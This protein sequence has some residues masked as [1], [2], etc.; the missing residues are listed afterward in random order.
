M[1]DENVIREVNY[2]QDNNGC[3]IPIGFTKRTDGYWQFQHKGKK[4]PVHRYNYESTKGIIPKGYVLRHECDNRECV[5][6]EHLLPGTHADNVRDR[7]LRGRSATGSDN[8]RSKLTEDLVRE[9][10]QS[11]L[12]PTILAKQYGIDRKAIYNIRQGLNWRHVT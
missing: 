7:V 9:I 11:E 4:V 2:I 1:G 6:P 12:P 8:G 3:H 10:K 5:N